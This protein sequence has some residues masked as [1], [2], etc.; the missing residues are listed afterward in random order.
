[1]DLTE[2]ER[3]KFELAAILRDA[4]VVLRREMPDLRDPFIDLFAR[5]AEDRFNLVVVGRFSRGKTSLMNAML[6]TDRLPTGIVPLTSVITTVSYGSSERAFI[7]HE[8]WALDQEISLNALPDFVTQKGNPGN[9]RGVAVARVELPAELLRR[10]FHFVD[11]PGLGSSIVENT[12]TTERFLPEADAFMLVT[13]Y[14]SP[15]S[16]EELRVLQGIATSA[17]RLFLV[18]NKHDLVSPEERNQVLGHVREQARRVFGEPLPRVFS[19]SARDAM[20]ATALRDHERFLASGIGELRD[21][22]ARFVLNEKQ[23]EFLLRMC[24]RVA[25]ALRGVAH[26]GEEAERLRSLHEEIARQR[27]SAVPLVAVSDLGT[28]EVMPQFVSCGICAQLERGIYKYLCGYQYDIIVRRDLQA[29]FTASGGLCPFHTWQYEA[30]ATPRGTCIGFSGLLEQLAVRLREAAVAAPADAC[31]GE[32]DKLRPTAQSCDLCRVRADLE[33]TAVTTLARSFVAADTRSKGRFTGLCLDHLRLVLAAIGPGE[34]AKTLLMVEAT[35]ME[36]VSEDMRR[37]ALKH[38]GVRRDLAS[39]EE[40]SAAKRA[41]ILV[42]GHR[43]VNGLWK[44]Q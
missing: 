14:D 36:R 24:E 16:E 1:M 40:L 21:E 33:R 19:V 31:P 9:R 29:A 34:E 10:G 41:L 43:N 3:A 7:E 35:L 4:A 30:L 15:L 38:D 5:L 42:A 20:E 22:L 25:D 13:S 23:A 27:P 17:S 28:T 26:P 18:I 11:T 37:Y 39:E 12:R 6:D 44:L 8:G 2:Y 32:I